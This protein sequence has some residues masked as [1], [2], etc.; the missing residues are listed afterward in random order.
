MSYVLKEYHKYSVFSVPGGLAIK[1]SA[2]SLRPVTLVVQVQ[3]LAQEL[4]PHAL[5]GAKRGK[6]KKKKKFWEF[7]PGPSG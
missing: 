5:G 4:H 7:P 1:D 6:K 3:T 2:L